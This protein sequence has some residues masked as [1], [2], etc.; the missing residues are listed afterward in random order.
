MDESE[1]QF[2]KVTMP[3]VNTISV[4]GV[5]DD[6]SYAAGY[7]VGYLDFRLLQAS[8]I[9][10]DGIATTMFKDNLEQ[11]DL[12]AMK[13]GYKIESKEESECGNWITLLFTLADNI[14]EL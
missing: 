9:D 4:G 3:I 8:I 14:L 5:F 10:A 7:E 6:S 12:I 1:E 11:A 2:Q 13:H